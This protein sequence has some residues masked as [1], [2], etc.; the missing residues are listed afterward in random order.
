MGSFYFAVLKES[1]LNFFRDNCLKLS[2]ALA[3]YTVFSIGP[4]LLVVIAIAGY[5]FGRDAIEGEVFFQLRNLVGSAPAAQIQQI[6]QNAKLSDHTLLASIFGV[7][8]LIIGATG[9]FSEIQDSINLI[10]Q[11]KPKPRKG[12][13]L[14]LIN[15]IISFSMVVGLGFIIIVSL[16]ASALISALGKK[17][18]AMYPELAIYFIQGFNHLLSFATITLLFAVIFKVLPDAKIKWKDVW[19]GSLLTSILFLIG[20]FL[21]GYYIGNSNIGS[22]FG[23]AGAIIILLLWVNYSSIILYFGAEFTQCFCQKRGRRIQP[24]D[25]ATWVENQQVETVSEPEKG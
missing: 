4:M 8:T 25:Y 3:Y 14:F 7:I 5:F 15:R 13:I 22:T 19:V 10:W 6:I 11:L 12:L 21:I 1:L 23:A 20:K 17:L 16:V 24:N 2:A 18:H 9:V